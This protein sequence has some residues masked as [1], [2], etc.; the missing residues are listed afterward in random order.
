MVFFNKKIVLSSVIM[1]ISIVQIIG[2]MT[3]SWTTT[4]SSSKGLWEY[5][6]KAKDGKIKCKSIK[7]LPTNLHKSLKI[8]RFLAISGAVC[9][10][11]GL[12]SLSTSINVSKLTQPLHQYHDI[13]IMVGGLFSIASAVMWANNTSL[14]NGKEKLGY[15][16]YATLLGGILA[17]V[18]GLSDFA[19]H[20]NTVP[21]LL[22]VITLGKKNKGSKGKGS[23]GKGSKGKGSKGKDSKKHL[24]RI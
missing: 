13:L 4:K 20:G 19:Y 21:K 10:A 5:C 22:R 7:K 23:K 3:S 8:I 17:F 15:S 12:V 24:S 1:I 11:L 9:T 2:L 16:W 18:F 6:L 14:T